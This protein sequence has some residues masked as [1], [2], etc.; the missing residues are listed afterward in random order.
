MTGLE[1]NVSGERITGTEGNDKVRNF[2]H[3]EI[4]DWAI[5]EH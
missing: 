1:G 3:Y 5:W 4:L 2:G